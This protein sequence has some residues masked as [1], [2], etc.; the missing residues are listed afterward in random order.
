MRAT[1]I[2]FFLLLTASIALAL[3]KIYI[4]KLNYNEGNFT[5][6]N[7][8]V[9]EGF[10]RGKD[11]NENLEYKIKV[12]SYKG[13]ILWE[14]RLDIGNVIYFSPP[15]AEDDK[16]FL[17]GPIILK[18]V[19]ITEALPYFNDARYIKVYYKD[20]EVFSID[21]SKFS[22]YCGNNICNIG[23]D[24]GNC[25]DDCIRKEAAKKPF[26]W[27]IGLLFVLILIVYIVYRRNKR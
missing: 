2:F 21:I 11:F 25:P 14:N 3:D 15:I 23:E 22:N 18:D 4:V 16:P 19:N 20:S 24:S 9:T 6:D 13:S 5:L 1:M 8:K 27:I 7:I 17:R 10:Y 26:L 12:I